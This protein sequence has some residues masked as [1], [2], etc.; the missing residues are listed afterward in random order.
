MPSVREIASHLITRGGK[1]GLHFEN[2]GLVRLDIE[3]FDP[4]TGTLAFALLPKQLQII[5]AS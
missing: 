5:A 3:S 4:P 1:A 2:G